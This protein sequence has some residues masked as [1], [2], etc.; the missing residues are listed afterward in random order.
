MK[1]GNMCL[2]IQELNLKASVIDHPRSLS[3]ERKN[4]EFLLC[5]FAH[6]GEVSDDSTTYVYVDG[7]RI[8][9]DKLAAI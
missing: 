3:F 2:D 6:T 8:R 5:S 7:S 4:T 1:H 9:Q